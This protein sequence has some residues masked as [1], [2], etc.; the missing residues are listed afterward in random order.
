MGKNSALQVLLAVI[1]IILVL[2]F[3]GMVGGWEGFIFVANNVLIY[4]WPLLL[5]VGII[6]LL[7]ALSPD[8]SS[9]PA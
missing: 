5:I 4:A 9:A 6:F 7:I 2:V 3:A 8:K 1:T